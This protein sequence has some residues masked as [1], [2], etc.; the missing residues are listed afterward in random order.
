MPA[1]RDWR[2]MHRA[3]QEQQQINEL[4][5]ETEAKSGARML[6][7]VRRPAPILKYRGSVR[8]W[9]GTHRPASDG[10]R[11]STP[12]LGGTFIP[13]SR[14]RSFRAR[15]PRLHY[16]PYSPFVRLFDRLLAE[17]E[18]GQYA[19][20]RRSSYAAFSRMGQQRVG[21]SSSSDSSWRS[22]LGGSF[23]GGGSSGSRLT[24]QRSRYPVFFNF[25][26][27]CLRNFAIFGA[28]ANWQ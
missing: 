12:R 16:S 18:V 1:A 8:H 6:I 19:H 23:G 4:V 17:A 15:V 13:D 22:S 3:E 28:T 2:A 20:R 7:L 24:R 27:K 14:L 11:A 9:R 25:S 10:R 21:G 5:A 26:R